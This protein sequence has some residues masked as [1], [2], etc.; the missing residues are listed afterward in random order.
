MIILKKK[1]L[2]NGFYTIYQNGKC[3]NESKLKSWR[4]YCDFNSEP[5]YAW[6]L[7]ESFSLA[8]DGIVRMGFY[9]S[10]A[11]PPLSDKSYWPLYRMSYYLMREIKRVDGDL[12]CQLEQWRATCN[13]NA[14]VLPF[15][16][17]PVDYIRSHFSKAD[18]LSK[19]SSIGCYYI[20]YLNIRG[21]WIEQSSAIISNYHDHI[22]LS[23][24]K[25]CKGEYFPKTM[26]GETNFGKYDEKNVNK[27]F[28]CTASL[29]HTTNWWI[30][31]KINVSIQE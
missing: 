18:I 26:K 2:P 22:F 24:S 12:T 13:F 29:N 25:S 1:R 8:N 21:Y 5:G 4:V 30:G 27:E 16:N 3:K 9:N 14:K 20:D 23:S 19:E 6:T 17:R 28:S 15:R 10:S 11:I 31:G 7:I